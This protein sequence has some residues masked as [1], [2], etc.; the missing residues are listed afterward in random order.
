M[1]EFIIHIIYPSCLL[2]YYHLTQSNQLFFKTKIQIDPLL[3]LNGKAHPITENPILDI[4]DLADYLLWKFLVVR[5]LTWAVCVRC[6]F[7][8]K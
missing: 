4:A 3:C 2:V 5:T 7:C 1:I 6:Y 8:I